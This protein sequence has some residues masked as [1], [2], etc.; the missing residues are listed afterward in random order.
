MQNCLSCRNN[1]GLLS[2][3]PTIF[4]G[5]SICPEF[6][7]GKTFADGWTHRIIIKMS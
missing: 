4:A 5:M 1:T 6:N 2:K 7:L 3:Y